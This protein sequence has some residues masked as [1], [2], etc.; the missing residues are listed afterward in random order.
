VKVYSVT[1]RGNEIVVNEAEARETEKLVILDTYTNGF[2]RMRYRKEHLEKH[3][4]GRT[5][6][7][8]LNLAYERTLRSWKHAIAQEERLNLQLTELHK[9]RVAQQEEDDG[10]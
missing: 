10:A 1:F 2:V 8:A 9:L 5:R 3:D 7:E 6:L 4:I